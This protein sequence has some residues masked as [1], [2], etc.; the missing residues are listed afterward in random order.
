MA[1]FYFILNEGYLLTSL[2]Y[3][4]FSETN[5]Q[6]VDCLLSFDVQWYC[7]PYQVVVI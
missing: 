3:K 2:E 1:F 6:V 4:T 7:N 5:V